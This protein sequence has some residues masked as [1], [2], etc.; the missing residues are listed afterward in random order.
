MVT[1][2]FDST[3]P[4]S[5]TKTIPSYLYTNYNDDADLQA[6]IRA[7]NDQT[8]P[9][10]DWFNANNLAVWNLIGG[11]LL[12]WIATGIYGID[13]PT[14]PAVTDYLIGPIDT[15]AQNEL[16]I[17]DFANIQ[18]SSYVLAGDGVYKRT[19]TWSLWRGDGRVF[20]IRWLKRRIQRFL[21]GGG[22]GA[23]QTDSTYNVSVTFVGGNVVRIH[24]LNQNGNAMSGQL[25]YGI[26]SGALPL[27]FQFVFVVDI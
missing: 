9:Y 12:D 16:A 17:N 26:R 15:V 10:V 22:G 24:L 2:P 3:W 19:I 6:F 20:N 8:Q 7:Y 14:F 25:Q 18:P 13:R 5:L 1:L 21:T 11:P 4:G 27:P 23:G